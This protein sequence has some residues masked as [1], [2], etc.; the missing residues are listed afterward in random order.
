MIAFS[1][2]VFLS[3]MAVSEQVGCMYWIPRT[4]FVVRVFPTLISFFDI[5]NSES[6]EI[7]TWALNFTHKIDTFRVECDWDR[8]RIIITLQSNKNVSVLFLQMH[9]THLSCLFSFVRG[10]S[11]CISSNSGAQIATLTRGDAIEISIDGAFRLGHK[12]ISDCSNIVIPRLTFGSHKKK[13]FHFFDRKCAPEDIFPCLY[14]ISNLVPNEVNQSVKC[15]ISNKELL[16]LDFPYVWKY[17][18]S[19]TM[20]PFWKDQR[21]YGNGPFFEG[22]GS[23]LQIFSYFGKALTDALIRMDE[24]TLSILPDLPKWSIAGRLRNFVLPFGSFSLIWSNGRLRSCLLKIEKS[25][26][27]YFIFPPGVRVFRATRKGGGP[28]MYHVVGSEHVP[29]FFKEGD[30]Y[31]FDRF[32]H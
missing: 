14:A 15:N 8:Q 20:V 10:K 6:C 13:C 21:F 31:C 5:R 30:I 7:C 4:F 32:E 3:Y 28:G 1:V 16:H 17:H 12:T 2:P 27:C 22:Y 29:F 19:A 23:P 11:L 26:L 9:Q 24:L 18:F 25:Y